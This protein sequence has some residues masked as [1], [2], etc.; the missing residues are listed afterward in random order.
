MPRYFLMY[1]VV[2]ITNKARKSVHNIKEAEREVHR[3]RML[4]EN[5]GM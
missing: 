3:C 1:C 4:S 2:K 5:G